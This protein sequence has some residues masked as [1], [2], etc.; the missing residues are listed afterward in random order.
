MNEVVQTIEKAGISVQIEVPCEKYESEIQDILNQIEDVS[1]NQSYLMSSTEK[2][3]ICKNVLKSSG[4][5]GSYNVK[6]GVYAGY[7]DTETKTIYVSVKN[8]VEDTIEHEMFHQFDSS[9]GDAPL[10]SSDEFYNLA[11]E[12]YGSIQAIFNYNRYQTMNTSEFF[13]ALAL[14]YA[15]ELESKTLKINFPDIYE[16]IDKYV[17]Q[18]IEEKGGQD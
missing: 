3:V 16:Y 18:R 17:S 9:F 8:Y 15:D 7:A 14:D 1:K 6:K 4:T 12:N 10:S 11:N 2:V 13:V 5:K